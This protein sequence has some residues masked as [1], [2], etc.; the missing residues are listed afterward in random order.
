MY[1]FVMFVLTR[2]GHSCTHMCVNRENNYVQ[3]KAYVF[4]IRFPYS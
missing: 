3:G 1:N 2:Q 4:V